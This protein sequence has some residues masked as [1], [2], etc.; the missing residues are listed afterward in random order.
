MS[1]QE[2]LELPACPPF[3]ETTL[4]QEQQVFV[5]IV[6]GNEFGNDVDRLRK[7][8]RDISIYVPELPAPF[9][10][11]ELD[12]IIREINGLSETIM[13]QQ[14][15][16]EADANMIVFFGDGATYVREYEEQAA[17]LTESN[18]GLFSIDWNR[19]TYEISRAT[20]WVDTVNETDPDCLRH[21]LREELTQALGLAND[22][23]EYP[24]S[25]F[26]SV[27]TCTPAYSELDKTYLVDFLSPSLRA[28]MCEAEVIGVLF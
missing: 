24:E 8:R 1:C 15:Q 26:Y 21:I 13:L 25:I 14:V 10:Q 12:S 6:F 9:L 11:N 16:R 7:W 3:D 4:S 19:Q 28:G 17:G 5:D 23:D 20:V 27:Y 22:T 2:D 18:R